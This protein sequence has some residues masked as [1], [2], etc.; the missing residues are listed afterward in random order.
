MNTNQPQW[1]YIDN[2]GDRHPIDHGGKFVYVDE[3]GVYEPEVEILEQPSEED[4]A[5]SERREQKAALEFERACKAVCGH[6]QTHVECQCGQEPPEFVDPLLLWTVYRFT[7][8]N[9]TYLD[10]ILSDNKFYPKLPAWFAKPESE[11]SERPQDTTYLKGI[12]D[13]MDLDVD[14]YALMFVHPWALTRAQAWIEVGE[15][16][17]WANLDSYPI[18]LT[19]KEVEERYKEEMKRR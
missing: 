9:C 6:D 1:K 16:H 10:G 11:R 17:G 15:Y 19:R 13:S 12:A 4:F 7:I 14:D 18:T 5:A 3:T 8:E 2:L